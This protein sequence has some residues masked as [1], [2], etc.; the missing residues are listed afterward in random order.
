MV[1]H[2]ALPGQDIEAH[3]IEEFVAEFNE[4]HADIDTLLLKLEKNAGDSN[5][6]N[7]LFRKVHTIKGNAQLIG[8]NLIAGFV[9]V[10][11]HILDRL[12]KGELVFDKLLGDVILRSVDHIGK[13][14]NDVRNAQTS[15]AERTLELQSELQQLATADQ[16]QLTTV[17]QRINNVFSGNT[18]LPLVNEAPQ[19]Q[20]SSHVNVQT[21]SHVNV[22]TGNTTRP[23]VNEAPQ[24]QASSHVNMVSPQLEDLRFFARIIENAE[25]RPPFWNGRSQRILN[26]ALDMNNEAG[27]KVDNAQLEAAVYLHDFGM[28]FLPLHIL[29]KG[30]RLTEEEYRSLQLHPRMGAALLGDNPHWQQAA[31][32]IIQHHEREDGRGY[33]AQLAGNQIC[34]GAK[35]LAIADSFEAM[36]NQRA[37]RANRIPFAQALR[38][39]NQHAGSQFSTFW[40]DTFINVVRKKTRKS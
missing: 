20:T 29:H 24:L 9:H 18:T 2:Q 28:A 38:E 8:L 17:C 35:I 40:T 37:N 3:I 30:D 39:I 1:Q 26:I 19:L 22:V 36:T 11:E 21:S 10:L 5:L 23:L 6:L 4:T 33:P 15:H 12:R 27:L 25:Q 7:E 32:M 16:S 13:L 31:D 34:D 14:C